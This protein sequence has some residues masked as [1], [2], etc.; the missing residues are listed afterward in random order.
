MKLLKLLYEKKYKKSVPYYYDYSLLTILLKPVR[1]WVTNTLA[2]NC[3]FNCVRIWLYR[4]CGFKIGKKVF[5]GMKCYLDD[6]CYDLLEIGNN[7]T[8]SYG[9]FFACHG[10]NQEHF[11]IVIGDNV[12]IGMRANIISKNKIIQGGGIRIGEGAIV[13]ACTLVNQS[14]PNDATAVGIPC[15][16]IQQYKKGEN[17]YEG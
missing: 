15:R 12:Y 17:M 3:P 11:P 14:I 7:V 16:L 4:M 13:G 2:A 9:V 1:K 10:K 6:M 5:I 8:I